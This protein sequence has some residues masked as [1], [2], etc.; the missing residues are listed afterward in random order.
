MLSIDFERC[1][2]KGNVAIKEAHVGAST[3]YSVYAKLAYGIQS[4]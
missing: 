1:R 4:F 3:A 2:P